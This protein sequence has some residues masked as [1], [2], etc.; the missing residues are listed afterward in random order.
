MLGSKLFLV[1]I[2]TT[3]AEVTQCNPKCFAD[4][5]H[6]SL[7]PLYE[8][9]VMT[10]SII[11]LGMQS[12]PGLGKKKKKTLNLPHLALLP[13]SFQLLAT[14]LTLLTAEQMGL[15]APLVYGRLSNR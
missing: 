5:A 14:E 11:L 13:G 10:C 3:I 7:P 8:G 4:Y 6:L 2:Y 12:F 1:S 15:N 9:L